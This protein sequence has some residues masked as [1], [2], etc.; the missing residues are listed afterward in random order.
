MAKERAEQDGRLSLLAISEKLD[1]NKWA[2]PVISLFLGKI[3]QENVVEIVWGDAD[4]VFEG[5]H[6]EAYFYLG[7]YNV[8][9]GNRNKAKSFFESALDTGAKQYLE[10]AGAEIELSRLDE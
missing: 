5:R 7:E 2:G 8:L 10:Y 6:C 1:L 3:S 9:K 4:G